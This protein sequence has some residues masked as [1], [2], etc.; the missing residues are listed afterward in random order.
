MLSG[1]KVASEQLGEDLAQE[2]KDE[3]SL[4]SW[5]PW[6]KELASYAIGAALAPLTGGTSLL[7]SGLIK[8]G[9]AFATDTMGDWLARDVMG[10]GGQM[11][12][13]S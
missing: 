5:L 10:L 4:Q 9:T 12:K 2:R 6:A 7:L 3:Q 8:S 13:A 1:Q 11:G